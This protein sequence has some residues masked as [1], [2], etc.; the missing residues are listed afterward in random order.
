MRSFSKSLV[1]RGLRARKEGKSHLLQTPAV[2]A[3]LELLLWG[4]VSPSN[5]SRHSKIVVE[6]IKQDVSN[7]KKEGGAWPAWLRD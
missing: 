3:H 6:I 7:L 4:G 5:N 2:R 1:V